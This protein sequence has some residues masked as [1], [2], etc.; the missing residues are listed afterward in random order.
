M[1]A[2]IARFSGLSPFEATSS[3]TAKAKMPATAGQCPSRS[4]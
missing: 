1:S 3:I 4:G 2:A